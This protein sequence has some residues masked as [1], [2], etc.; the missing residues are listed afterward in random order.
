MP[1][2]WTV[3]HGTR[4]I[5]DFLAL[6]RAHRIAILADVR[7]FPGSRRHPQFN[8]AAL[9]A[10]VEGA[11]V[12]YAHLPELGGLREGGYEAH[13]RTPTWQAGFARLAALAEEGRTA[14][15]CAEADPA[16]CHRRLIARHAAAHGWEVRHI[17]DAARA[18]RER[19]GRQATLPGT[20]TEGSSGP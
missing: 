18:E 6:L 15:L 2:L 17:R 5:E 9:C 13:M 1:E 14:I 10:A 11:G 7:S 8:Q 20:G 16:R 19:G 12:R 4:P 3:G